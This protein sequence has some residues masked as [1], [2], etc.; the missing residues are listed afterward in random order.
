[1]DATPPLQDC[2]KRYCA[3]CEVTS[4]NMDAI[5]PLQDYLKRYCA[6]C[7]VTSNWAAKVG[8]G[9]IGVR[10]VVGKQLLLGDVVT[11]HAEHE[12]Y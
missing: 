4:G 6:I 9:F 2:L 1:M 8:D 11:W 12:L 3:I 5:P 7:G 10:R